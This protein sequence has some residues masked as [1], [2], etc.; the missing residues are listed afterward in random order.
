MYKKNNGKSNTKKIS[1]IR[2]WYPNIS[3]INTD[4]M[5][6]QSHNLVLDLTTPTL[7]K[8]SFQNDY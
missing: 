3:V 4:V 1:K 2:I 8:H 5:I 7:S 6:Y